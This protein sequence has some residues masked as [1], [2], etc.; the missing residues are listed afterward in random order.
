MKVSTAIL[1]PGVHSYF[2]R[3]I[4]ISWVQRPHKEFCVF[5]ILN[6]VC[7][8]ML[9]KKSLALLPSAKAIHYSL[10][11]FSSNIFCSTSVKTLGK[12]E[13]IRGRKRFHKK[14]SS[15]TIFC[16]GTPTSQ[17]PCRLRTCA[18]LTFAR[19]FRNQ[20]R[21]LDQSLPAP[22]LPSPS[23]LF[24]FSSALNGLFEV[25]D[26]QTFGCTAAD[27]STV[28]KREKLAHCFTQCLA[29]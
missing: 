3:D 22:A 29:I 12:W 7:D 25:K 2:L 4:A 8:P 10:R 13:N 11:F 28:S 15:M 6:K 18:R 17:I 20:F 16:S 27:W 23:P 9:R 26:E 24:H 5:I 1:A 19:A 14:L 21:T